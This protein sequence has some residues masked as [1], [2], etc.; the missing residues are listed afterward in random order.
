MNTNMKKVKTTM[1]MTVM[2]ALML[3]PMGAKAQYREDQFGIQPWF[4]SSL[5]GRDNSDNGYSKTGG[6]EDFL[7]LPSLHGSYDDFNSTSP[8]G[9][10]IAVLMGLGAAYLVAKRRKED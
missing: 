4:G 5:M 9:S 1:F 7:Y 8:M 6:E 10:G 3:L 2:A